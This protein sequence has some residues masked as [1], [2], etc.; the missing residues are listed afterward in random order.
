MLSCFPDYSLLKSSLI[1]KKEKK[2][3]QKTQILSRSQNYCTKHK[4][5]EANLKKSLY[6]VSET[7]LPIFK[8]KS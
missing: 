7:G 6:I 3:Q 8:L 2:K 1:I 4:R 5:Y